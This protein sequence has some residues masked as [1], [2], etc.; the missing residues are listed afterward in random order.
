MSEDNHPDKKDLKDGSTEG[1]PGY[2]LD[3]AGRSLSEAL[4]ISFL[5]LKVIMV[6]LVLVFLA[7]GFRTVG[8]DEE[9]LVLRFGRIRPVGTQRVLGPGPHWV[10][11]Y[12]IDQIVKIPVGKKINL[13]INS[14]WYY[15]TEQEMLLDEED[16]KK[17]RIPQK[18]D[19]IKDGY[20]ITRSEQGRKAEIAFGGSDYNIVHSRWQLVYQIEYPERF[21]KNVYVK[22]V[23]PGQDYFDVITGSITPFLEN[24]VRDA[25]VTAMVGY[26]IDEAISSQD[27]IPK[28]V[29]TLL[30]AKLNKI[31]SG[32]KI[33]SVQLTES[34]WP[35]QV[36]EAFQKFISAGQDRQRLIAKAR[37]YY[38]RTLNEAAGPVAEPL[39]EVV[40]G[41]KVLSKQEE[42]PLWE[43][44]AGAAREEIAQALAYR[45]E[46]VETARA[47]S[48]YLQ[49]ILPEYRKRPELVLQRVYLA[50]IEH[51]FGS[52]DEKFFMS[53]GE[54]SKGREIRIMLNRDPSIKRN[55]E[56]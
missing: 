40:S 52:A 3:A 19:P 36:D 49:K 8:P 13:P 27:R 2:E 11:P 35:R 4:R 20:C 16:R 38:E 37:T 31:E 44:L 51:I 48:D 39:F 41:E 32:I 17:I 53:P 6:V 30:Q 50:A 22:D 15:Q 47:N 55:T 1:R 12:P 29:R 18:L 10:F 26:T 42:E 21:F 7:S 9:A 23:K 34:K 33:V 25:I 28:S 14:F 43:N 5:I 56:E 46:V 24:M 45:T 54:D